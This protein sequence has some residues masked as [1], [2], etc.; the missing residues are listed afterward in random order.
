MS[1]FKIVHDKGTN[2]FTVHGSAY[3]GDALGTFSYDSPDP[4]TFNANAL[5]AVRDL[6]AENELPTKSMSLQITPAA[7]A[8]ANEPVRKLEEEFSADSELVGSQVVP[9]R[10]SIENSTQVVPVET[11]TLQSRDRHQ[12]ADIEVPEDKAK[13]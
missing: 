13:D 6:M 9:G 10:A 2:L 7:Y 11:Q 1:E 8:Q 3:E 5:L 12:K 4:R